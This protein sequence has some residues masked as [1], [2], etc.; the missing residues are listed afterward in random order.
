MPALRVRT[1][2]LGTWLA[3]RG[4]LA[5]VGIA[6][7]ILATLASV[8][9]A[10]VVSRSEGNVAAQLPTLESS[11]IAWSAG[12]VL[13]FGAALRAI[14]RDRDQGILALVR[15]RGA[16]LAAYV[17]GRVGGVVVLLAI[18]VGGATLVGGLAAVSVAR[19]VAPAVRAAVAAL[20]YALAFAGTIGPVAVAVLGAR[21]R[22]GGYLSLLAVL[23]VP[24]MLAPWTASLLP[25]GWHEL[26]SVPAA[27]A[28]VRAGVASPVE[29]ADSLM[30]ALAGLV[31][32]VAIALVVVAAR[33]RPGHTGDEA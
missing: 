10:V 5:T 15:L 7:T 1:L 29:R 20:V 22:A 30:R 6:L 24:E 19:P 33:A 9:A 3:S 31:A 23:V 18:A 32:V 26:T 21:T 12:A 13:A 14:G 27:L 11:A 2:P 8:A 16:G 17:R 28:A 25:R 4:A